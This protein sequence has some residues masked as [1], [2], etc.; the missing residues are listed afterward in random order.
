MVGNQGL[1]GMLIV[2]VVTVPFTCTPV[3]VAEQKRPYVP[4]VE[5]FHGKVLE[6]L[7]VVDQEKI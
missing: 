6:A 5:G 4:V 2:G 7:V 1:T 3:Q